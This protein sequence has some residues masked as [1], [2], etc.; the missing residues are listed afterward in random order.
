VEIKEITGSTMT[1][2]LDWAD[3]ALLARALKEGDYGQLSGDTDVAVRAMGAAFEVAALAAYMQGASSAERITLE[4]W[5]ER[6]AEE[7]APVTRMTSD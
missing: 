4:T 7:Q 6:D 2:E 1:I 5:R 3:A